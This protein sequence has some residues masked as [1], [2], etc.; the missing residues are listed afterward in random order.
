MNEREI[1]EARVAALESLIED[2]MNRVGMYRE[3]DL[4]G[5]ARLFGVEAKARAIQASEER[6]ERERK[7]KEDETKVLEMEADFQRVKAAGPVGR[8]EV[9]HHSGMHQDENGNQWFKPWFG[10]DEWQLSDEHFFGDLR[11]TR[12]SMWLAAMM[13]DASL[14]PESSSDSPP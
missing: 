10:P 2:V 12:N 6:A 14:R 8:L 4:P 5:G 7:A 9:S 3:V 13:I 1:L 11:R